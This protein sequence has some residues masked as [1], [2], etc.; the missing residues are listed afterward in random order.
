MSL[1]NR[2]RAL[3]LWLL[4]S[5]R[6]VGLTAL[7]LLAAGL[8]GVV[9]F[10]WLGVYNVAASTGHFRIVELFLHF[11]MENSVK[12]RAPDT[13][14]V[15]R[16]DEDL[17][18]LGA[19]HFHG[20]CAY[21][22]GAPGIP[23]TPVSASMLPAPPDLSEK[24]GFWKDGE[25]FWIVQHGLKYTGMPGWPA[26]AR[27]DEVW[28]LVAFMRRLPSLD[29]KGYRALAQGEVVTD[30]PD[31]PAIATGRRSRDAIDAC[32]RCHG[33]REAPPSRLVPTL[34]GQSKTMLAAALRAY[35]AGER[36]S[37]VMQ[38]V[39]SGLSDGA[40]DE[41]AAYY[42]A[43]PA[44]VARDRASADPAAIERGAV[45]AREGVPSREVPACLSC[46]GPGA[47]PAYPRLAGQSARYLAGQLSVWRAGMNDRSE[48]GAIMAPIARRLSAQQADDLAA[49]FASLPPAAP[50]A[51]EPGR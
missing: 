11:G 8:A 25:L 46:H 10:A 49:Y 34:H 3:S 45:L 7:A 30:P 14:L 35:A 43:L 17:I 9:L 36:P 26:L 37:G 44:P 13:T 20:G 5:W 2:A 51:D 40:I 15:R 32:A 22:H 38:T 19:G 29:E 48:T 21:C 28:A 16:D 39:V 31:G 33:A 6:R 27:E 23:I 24:V 47:L 18:R 42:A 4:A 50:I 12:A 1:L 41:L